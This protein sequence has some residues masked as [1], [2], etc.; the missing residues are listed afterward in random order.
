M[1]DEPEQQELFPPLHRSLQRRRLM[2]KH[3][4]NPER[5]YAATWHQWNRRHFAFNNGWRLLEGILDPEC[6]RRRPP[7]V[8]RRDAVAIAC[9]V[10]W[11]GTNVGRGFVHECEKRISESQDADVIRARHA[12]LKDTNRWRSERL[13]EMM[14]ELDAEQRRFNK[15]LL[16]M[17]QRLAEAKRLKEVAL[18]RAELAYADALV[19]LDVARENARL[20]RLKAR[21]ELGLHP[22][23]DVELG[24]ASRIRR[25]IVL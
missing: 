11:L 17:E 18:R 7:V 6:E 1:A 24:A 12:G 3:P 13:M 10:Q 22:T 20:A 21:K 25:G 15:D 8:T 14:A 9:F 23:L 16:E 5:I 19:A 4:T 2:R